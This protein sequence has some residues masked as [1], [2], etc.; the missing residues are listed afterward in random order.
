MADCEAVKRELGDGGCD[1]WRVHRGERSAYRARIR[2]DKS[3]GLFDDETNVEGRKREILDMHCGVL[4][5]ERGYNFPRELTDVVSNEQ[6]A[7]YRVRHV[8]HEKARDDDFDRVL[9][10][11][12]DAVELERDIHWRES[13]PS[14]PRFTLHLLLAK[15]VH[16][17]APAA[18]APTKMGHL[19]GELENAHNVYMPYSRLI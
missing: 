18:K 6:S 15:H 14:G 8:A 2:S 10:L 12:P 16:N 11:V 3:L 17:T 13:A 7:E 19:F 5:R 1:F 4:G 9:P